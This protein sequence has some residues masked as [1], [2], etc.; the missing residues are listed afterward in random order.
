LVIERER[1]SEKKREKVSGRKIQSE[2]RSRERGRRREGGMD[3]RSRNEW[4][5]IQ[6]RK[7]GNAK[8]PPNKRR[9]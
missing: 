8:K 3:K 9:R 4:K 1:D 6:N 2:F 7:P 5:R